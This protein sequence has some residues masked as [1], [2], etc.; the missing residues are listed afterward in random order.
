M[1]NGLTDELIDQIRNENDIVEVIGE[2]V[3]L[4]KQGKNY[5]GLCP[6]H[7]EKS[8]S[9]SVVKEKQFFHCFGCGKSGNVFN[10]LMEKETFTFIEAV[11][12]LAER[13]HID[14]KST[15]LNSS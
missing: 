14:R 1:A 2:Y 15:R 11:Q 3:Q 9:F 10:F 5:F 12:F 4:K 13:V 6:F 7:D 8:P